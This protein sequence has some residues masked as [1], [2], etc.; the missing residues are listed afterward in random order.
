MNAFAK[1]ASRS[2]G[3]PVLCLQVWQGEGTDGKMRAA[4]AVTLNPTVD[5]GYTEDELPLI[6]V[7]CLMRY[8]LPG[9]LLPFELASLEALFPG[10]VP[11]AARAEVTQDMLAC[12]GAD[13]LSVTF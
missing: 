10:P 5:P 8:M 3:E 12:V 6:A 13:M 2:C 1:A 7:A 11:P 4:F 9:Y